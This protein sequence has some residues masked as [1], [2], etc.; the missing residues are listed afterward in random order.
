[1]CGRVHV[2]VRPYIADVWVMLWQL[3]PYKVDKFKTNMDPWANAS[4]GLVLQEDHHE[5]IDT[6]EYRNVRRLSDTFLFWDKDCDDHIDSSISILEIAADATHALQRVF[7]YKYE[8][9]GPKQL[10]TKCL[11]FREQLG[12]DDNFA[13]QFKGFKYGFALK[14][15]YGKTQQMAAFKRWLTHMQR[16]G[17][18]T[19]LG[20]SRGRNHD[21]ECDA[22]YGT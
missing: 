13:L 3:N 14:H 21:V 5:D 6:F 20:Y 7:C 9:A 18:I 10:W 19:D 22:A 11:Y 17:F 8:D 15:T 2:R 16:N 1:M 12:P 4:A